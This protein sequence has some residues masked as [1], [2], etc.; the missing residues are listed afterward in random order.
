MTSTT[1]QPI[2]DYETDPAELADRELPALSCVWLEQRG[3]LDEAASGIVRFTERLK[4]EWAIETGLIERLYHLDRGITEL[5][6]ERGIDAALIPHRATDDTEQTVAMIGD[7]QQAV[8]SLFAFVRQDRQISTSYVKEL[9]ALFT[10]HQ[11]YAEGRDQFGQKGRVPL[12]HGGYKQAVNNPTRPDGTVHLYC[13]PEHVAAEMDRL[14]Q[15][16]QSH[17]DVAPEV[18]A[19]WL[20]HRFVQIHPFQ[21]GNG[22]L[23]RALATLVF[24]RQSWFPLV[25]RDKDRGPY[26]HALERADGGDLEPLVAFFSKLQRQEFIKAIGIARDIDRAVLVDGRIQSIRQQLAQRRDSLVQE[27]EAAKT[28]ARHLHE[29]AEKRMSQVRDM[30]NEAVN[31]YQQEFSFHV[32]DQG[33]S[34]EHSHY[35]RHQIVSTAKML[36][37]FADTRG[38]RSWVLLTARD[39]VQ[40]NI[41]ISFHGI[42]YEFQGVLV[43]SGTWFQRVPTDDGR[44]T[45]GETALCDEVFQINYK[46]DENAVR[47]RFEEW[48]EG[49]LAKG[50]ALWESTML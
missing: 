2:Q 12:I 13:P 35:Y 6:I 21:D 47:L 29:F 36:D 41:L 9:H 22:R 24:L 31:A 1:W 11:P 26:I 44:E 27:W 45:T 50:L 48:L 10:R 3:R 30:L 5:L 7:Q 19:A 18:Q 42:G 38:Y 33:D 17:V 28:T 23:A 4:R 8:E 40:S 15:W 46:E 16:H 32:R 20:H 49:V 34:D 39:G 14:I 25:V 43:C 37:Y